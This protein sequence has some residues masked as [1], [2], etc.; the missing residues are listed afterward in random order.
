MRVVGVVDPADDALL[1]SR[2]FI[3]QRSSEAEYER[4]DGRDRCALVAKRMQ[5]VQSRKDSVN[6]DGTRAMYLVVS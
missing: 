3:S 6:R 5:R 1:L 4:D 2:D